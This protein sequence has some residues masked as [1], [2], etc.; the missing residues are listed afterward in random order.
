MVAL[1]SRRGPLWVILPDIRPEKAPMEALAK[2]LAQHAGKPEDWRDWHEKL[3]GPDATTT[4]ERMVQDA[5]IGESRG[6]TVLLPVDQFEECFTTT[7][8][9]ERAAFLGLLQAAFARDLPFMVIATGRSDVLEGLIESSELV[10]HYETFPLT[11]M[12]LERYP[13]LIEGPAAVAGITVE[14]GLSERIGRDVES[15]EALPLLAYTLALLYRRGEED[16]RLNLAEYEALGDPARGLNPIENSIRLAAEEAIKRLNPSER[17]LDALRDAFVPHLVRVRL[18]DGKRVRQAA[19]RSELPAESLRLIGALTE[20]R[21]LTTRSS[22]AER[23]PLVEVTHEALFKAWPALDRWL[24][25]QQAFLTDL[26]RIRAA[27]ENYANAPNEQKSGELLYGLLLSRARDWL[28]KYPQRFVSRD[29]EPLRAYIAASA[30]VADAERAR[31]QRIRRSVFVGMAAAVVLLTAVAVIAILQYRDAEDSRISAEAARSEAVLAERRA[32]EEKLEAEKQRNRA[33]EQAKLAIEERNAALITQSRFLT[34]KANDV[35]KDGDYGTALALALEA[36]PDE[37]RGIK[38]PYVPA[39][40]SVLYRAAVTLREQRVF[41][42]SVRPKADE[43]HFVRLLPGGRSFITFSPRRNA[44]WVQDAATGKELFVLNGHKQGVT[45]VAFSIE[46]REIVTG[47]MDGTMRTWDAANGKPLRTFAGSGGAI[48]SVAVAPGGVR[49]VTASSDGTAQI[50]DATDEAAAPVV[51][52]MSKTSTEDV[53]KA[54]FSPDGS[55]VV[56]LSVPQPFVRLARVWDAKTGALLKV[57]G[58]ED[59]TGWTDGRYALTVRDAE[60][61]KTR[62]W[63]VASGDEIGELPRMYLD[64]LAAFA[65]D[66]SLIAV[67]SRNKVLAWGPAKSGSALP[68]TREWEVE[69]GVSH[70][71]VAPDGKR[72]AAFKD[73]TTMIWNVVD[74]RADRIA[75]EMPAA[76]LAAAEFFPDG[77]R[78]ATLLPDALRIW[79]ATHDVVTPLLHQAP[80]TRT[81]GAMLSPPAFSSDGRLIAAGST[82]RTAK[83]WDIASGTLLASKQHQNQVLAVALSAGRSPSRNRIR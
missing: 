35:F 41:A 46:R 22:D 65:A 37:R 21:L 23:E 49:I 77:R 71:V 6:A 47:S 32:S 82:D 83:V 55:R 30:E 68:F 4:L 34:D 43:E 72:I 28:L 81:M 62:V 63:D 73:R 40:E 12:P 18:D 33:E 42:G 56:T 25:D 79:D 61:A 15:K 48:S 54:A 66:G 78:I 44:P 39:A 27:H 24:T 58:D 60:D 74:I 31:Q 20:A 76:P 38:R 67:A 10:G 5:R 13:R 1:L 7:P 26:E 64:D 52:T 50:W 59:H 2:A 8:A 51:L 9:T 11:A 3:N 69:G 57:L 75:I 14:K 45:G 19:R 36:L 53:Q 29:M 80:L 17:E 70:P 16:N